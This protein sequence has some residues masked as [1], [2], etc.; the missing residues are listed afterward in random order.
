[1]LSALESLGAASLTLATLFR[2]HIQEL[3][4]TKFFLF[5]LT[6]CLAFCNTALAAETGDGS[7]TLNGET[8][9]SQKAFIRSGKRCGTRDVDA[10]EATAIR[11]ITNQRQGRIN[12]R[13]VGS[14]VVDV[15]FHVIRTNGGGG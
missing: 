5:L 3:I 14:V 6:S 2:T 13:P 15:W 1:M 7:F 10:I 9:T 11:S 4:M 12:H 8:W